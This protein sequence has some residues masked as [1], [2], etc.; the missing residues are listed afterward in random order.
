[1]PEIVNP[2]DQKMEVNVWDLV[3]QVIESRRHSLDL[4]REQLSNICSKEVESENVS[5]IFYSDPTYGPSWVFTDDGIGMDY[6]GNMERP[7]RLDRFLSIAYGGHAG[8]DA[9]EFGHKGL[10]A[11]LSLNCR[12][13]EVKT[14]SRQTGESYFAFV[15]HP[16][17]TLRS[18]EQLNF[19]LV[20]GAGTN[21]P[22]TE[23]K[24]LGY[25]RGL[26]Q[27]AYSIEEVRRYLFFYTIV[28]HTKD[29]EM[30]R[31]RLKVN[32]A[33]E[34]LNTG[35][36]YLISDGET[37]WKTYTLNE[38]LQFSET[39]DGNEVSVSLKGGFSLETA[40]PN[41]TGPF[42][43]TPRTSGLFLAT[44]GIP[45]IF[46]D[47]NSFRGE[48][49]GIQYKFCRFVSECDALFN[50][51]DLSRGAYSPGPV[52]LTFEKLLRKC[53]NTLGN[54]PEY[55]NYQKERERERQKQ[56]VKSLDERK[57]ALN[58][59][60]Q[61]YVFLKE[62]GMLLHRVPENE[63][64]ALALL[65]KLEGA[66]AIPIEKFESLEHTAQEGIDILSNFRLR[67]DSDLQRLIPVEVEDTFEEYFDHGHNPN[68]TGAIICWEME[69][70]NAPILEATKSP[71]LMYYNSSD[72]K[73]PVLIM[74]KFDSIEVKTR[75]P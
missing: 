22:G 3:S 43:L 16:L 17:D 30:P 32:E 20:P 33:E 6:T 61:K 4:V 73:I 72:R 68:Q 62:G 42:T 50:E 5:I 24:V 69:D 67:E 56:K 45:Y 9:D 2:I 29:R 19:K 1:M 34:M 31:I 63:H 21:T 53:F 26:G 15:D 70:P 14:N 71:W 39:V 23:V 59:P 64:D 66:G 55:K 75:T 65:W 27:N 40:N 51:M 60:T 11:S 8:Y 12:R 44:R 46:L 49:S 74:S 37:D 47:L 36:P 48:F 7:G 25:E 57:E 52:A 28:G 13:L 10:G 54:R 35:F 41:V 38:P 58:S 18:G